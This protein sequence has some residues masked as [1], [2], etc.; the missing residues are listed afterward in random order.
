MKKTFKG[1]TNNI[2]I[3]T[4]VSLEAFS[5]LSGSSSFS[6]SRSFNTSSSLETFPKKIQLL[7]HVTVSLGTYDVVQQCFGFKN[8]QTSWFVVPFNLPQIMV[9]NITERKIKISWFEKL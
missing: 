5:F 3:V 2:I 4:L 7:V 6:D 1:K 8:F 9:M